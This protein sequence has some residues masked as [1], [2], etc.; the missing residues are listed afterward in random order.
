M[1]V[2]R[3]VTGQRGVRQ[4]ESPASVPSSLALTFRE[5]LMQEF[6]ARRRI[7]KRC[8]LRAFAAM[9]DV[10]HATLSQIIRG[11]RNVPAQKIS[12][13]GRKLRLLSAEIAVYGAL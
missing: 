4:S 8:S 11:K 2:K 7:N 12:A 3:K 1:A 5:R 13:W 6:A 10:D 9:L